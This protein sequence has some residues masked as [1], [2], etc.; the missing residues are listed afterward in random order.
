MRY[1]YRYIYIYTVHREREIERQRAVKY[2]KLS[3]YQVKC[4][5]DIHTDIYIYISFTERE[6]EIETERDR[7]TVRDKDKCVNTMNNYKEYTRNNTK[8]YI[9]LTAN[10]LKERFTGHKQSFN[11][12]KF[13]HRT[14]SSYLW[15]LKDKDIPFSQRWSVVCQAPAYSRKVRACHLCLMEKLRISL[16]NIMTTLN[17]RNE[18]VAKCRHRDKLLLDKWWFFLP[19]LTKTTASYR[20][21]SPQL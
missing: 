14:L 2:I 5:W 19:I 3:E 20:A 11:H 16:A 18:I 17:K 13:A 12:Q 1:T 7:E 6:R 15:E 21:P 10:T 4:R 9:G 8:E